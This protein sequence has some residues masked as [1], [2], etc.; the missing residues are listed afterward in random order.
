MPQ[1]LYIDLNDGRASTS[2]SAFSAPVLYGVQGSPVTYDFAFHDAGVIRALALGDMPKLIMQLAS[3]TGG[4]T[5]RVI[6]S[7]GT[8]SGSGT[9]SRY[10]CS[11]VADN[12]A[13]RADFAAEAASLV[14]E[15]QLNWSE[16]SDAATRRTQGITLNL[17]VARDL[18]NSDTPDPVSELEDPDLYVSNRAVCYD[19]AQTLSNGEKQQALDNLGLNDSLSYR[20]G[21]IAVNST[22]VPGVRTEPTLQAALDVMVGLGVDNQYHAIEL[23]ITD[24]TGGIASADITLP[25]PASTLTLIGETSSLDISNVVSFGNVAMENFHCGIL[26]IN[27]SV[28]TTLLGS[29]TKL[30]AVTFSAVTG[31]TAVVLSGD[32]HILSWNGNAPA[33]AGS[34]GADG[35]YGVGLATSGPVRID[36]ATMIGGD[37]ESVATGNGGDGGLGGEITLGALGVIEVIAGGRNG[38]AGGATGGGGSAGADNSAVVASETH[39]P[40]SSFT[41]L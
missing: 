18:P 31:S 32:L 14:Y 33:P 17:D 20:P 28:I 19:R 3:A 2:L 30:D 6:G 41:Q 9:G 16:S 12:A 34:A 24:I 29:N 15:L 23:I 27:P 21:V 4:T 10:R 40:F 25:Y 5:P 35:F 13:V 26:T 1:L 37:G 22:Q 7:V 39:H 11:L 36:S 38:G 8:A